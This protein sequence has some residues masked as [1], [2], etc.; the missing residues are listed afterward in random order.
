VLTITV[1]AVESFDESKG[2][3]G[4]FVETGGFVLQLEH[5][6]ASLSKWEE[7]HEKPFLTKDDKTSEEV[8]SY[9]ECMIVT[10]DAPE[11]ALLSLSQENLDEINAYIDRKMTATWFSKNVGDGQKSTGEVITAE[12]IYHWMFAFNIPLEFEHRHL[13]KLFTQIKVSNAKNQKPKKMSRDE[14]ARQQREINRQRR[15]ATGSTG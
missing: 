1:G 7:I 10:P 5:S 13:N 14:W 4:E 12:L 9:I 2:E 15:E 8:L 3:Y 6:L 11:D